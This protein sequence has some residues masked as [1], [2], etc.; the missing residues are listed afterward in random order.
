VTPERQAV[1]PVIVLS[2]RTLRT[3]G[4]CSQGMALFDELLALQ[5]RKHAIRV[6]YTPLADLWL[7]VSVP[8]F[9][10]WLRACGLAP[11]A[12]LRCADLSGANLSDADRLFSDPPV[13]GWTYVNGLLTRRLP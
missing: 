13:D 12:N 1:G 10:R 5:G 6:R 8:S 11:R 2:R 9:A 3:L 7:S 4:A